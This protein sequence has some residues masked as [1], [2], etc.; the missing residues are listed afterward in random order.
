MAPGESTDVEYINK[1]KLWVL[2][3]ANRRNEFDCLNMWVTPL[4][5]TNKNGGNSFFPLNYRHHNERPVATC[6]E[7]PFQDDSLIGHATFSAFE[8]IQSAPFFATLPAIEI[9]STGLICTIGKLI[10]R[11]DAPVRTC[12]CECLPSQ[13]WPNVRMF[14]GL[15]RVRDYGLLCSF[16]CRSL[17]PNPV[18]F[19][20]QFMPIN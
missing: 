1:H 18:L 10:K 19:H 13:S 8:W 2:L 11:A 16:V 7:L 17:Y 4:D 3:I 9:D 6:A 20:I 15:E 14:A 5:D 12:G